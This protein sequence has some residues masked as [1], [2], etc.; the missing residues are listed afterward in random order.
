MS[1]ENFQDESADLVRIDPTRN[2]HR[3]YH[4]AVWP[5]L[6]GDVSLVREWGRIGQPGRQ[7]LD[8]HPDTA[9]A[10][11]KL[12]ELVRRKERRGYRRI[13]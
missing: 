6:F 8:P 13:A 10:Q 12:A 11:T 1:R 5:G 4:C 9:G 3:Y 7:R 2:Q